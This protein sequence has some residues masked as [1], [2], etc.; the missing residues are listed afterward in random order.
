MAL[1]RPG[2]AVGA[3]TRVVLRPLATPLPLAFLALGLA[4]TVFSALQ[5]GWI[6]PAD[7]RVAGLTAVV[8]SV[9]QLFSAAL[10]YLARDPV[11]GTGVGV[12]AGTW[13]LV[14]LTTLTSPPGATSRGLGVLLIA[15]AVAVLVPVAAG[16]SKLVPVAVL[17]V[18]A[19]RFAVT[20]GYELTA[21]PGW[22]AVAGWVG[23]GV[24]AVA[25]YAAVALELEGARRRTVLPLGRSGQAEDAVRGAAALDAGEL[26]REPGVRPRL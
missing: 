5:L 11:A 18:T 1:R 26:A 24:A 15:A 3:S 23:L 17:A 13:A 2:D 6:P 21:A 7:G 12:Q 4:T 9:L 22:K 8:A 20:G 10:G 25:L 19:A 16:G 14:G